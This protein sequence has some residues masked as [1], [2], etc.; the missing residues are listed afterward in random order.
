MFFSAAARGRRVERRS[1][2]LRAVFAIK[3]N[4]AS[5]SLRII[6]GIKKR[7]GDYFRGKCEGLTD[8]MASIGDPPLDPG[9]RLTPN[10][11]AASI[12]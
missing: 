7:I 5:H 4:C 8:D 11:I 3:T 2:A 9:R 12:D 10:L 6:N 1:V